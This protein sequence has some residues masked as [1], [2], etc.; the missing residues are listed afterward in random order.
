MARYLIQSGVTWEFLHADPRTGDV[1]WTPSLAAA[2]QFGV[3]DELDQVAQLQEDHCD[4]GLSL[5]V[6]LDAETP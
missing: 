2:L 4:R 3:I 1:C 6:D 5:V